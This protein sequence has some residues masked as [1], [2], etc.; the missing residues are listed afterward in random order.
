[1]KSNELRSDLIPVGGDFSIQLSASLDDIADGVG[2]V[3]CVWHPT[4]P[5]QSDFR[6]KIDLAL[7]QLAILQFSLEVKMS[8]H[9]E[10]QMP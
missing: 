4:M 9:S 6:S 8:I 1:M 7:Y 5:S 10:R 3:A 2:V